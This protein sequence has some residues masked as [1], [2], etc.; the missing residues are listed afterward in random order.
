MELFHL[1][2][3][4][5]SNLEIKFKL[6]HLPFTSAQACSGSSEITHS[7]ARNTLLLCLKGSQHV[8]PAFEEGSSKMFRRLN[9][10]F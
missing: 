6:Y 4:L 10:E 8:W 3:S 1:L 5:D 9:L 7:T 2:D